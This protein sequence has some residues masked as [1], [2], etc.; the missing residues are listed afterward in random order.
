MRSSMILEAEVFM[1]RSLEEI[2]SE[3]LEVLRR[4]E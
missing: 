3:R 2:G 4:S 1:E